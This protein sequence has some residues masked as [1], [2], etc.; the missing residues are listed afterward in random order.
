MTTKRPRSILDGVDALIAEWLGIAGKPRYGKEPLTSK[1]ALIDLS[2][3]VSP[4]VRPV[5]PS[6]SQFIASIVSR[7][8]ENHNVMGKPTPSPSNWQ[9]MK[10]PSIDFDNPSEEKLLEKALV[11]VMGDDW[12]NQISVCNSLAERKEYCRRVDLIHR[13]ADYEYE[14]IELKYGTEAQDHGT[15]TPLF[16]AMEL[17]QYGLVYL[18]SRAKRL[19][20]RQRGSLNLLSA[21]AIHLVVLA[22]AGYYTYK[23]TRGSKKGYDLGWLENCLN[24]GLCQYLQTCRGSLPTIDFHFQCLSPEFDSV[25]SASHA[26]PREIPLSASSL[27]MQELF[28]CHKFNVFSTRIFLIRS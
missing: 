23:T 9:W 15:D 20:G 25:Y 11:Q 3:N 6:A 1:Q 22:P 24:D 4:A 19:Y 17:L 21:K 27:P 13:L 7:I 16:A 14:L 18:F 2:E 26:K 5:Q 28:T 8:E 10:S 12:V